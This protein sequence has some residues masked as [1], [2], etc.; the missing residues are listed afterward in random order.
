[1]Q[2]AYIWSLNFINREIAYS[3]FQLLIFGFVQRMSKMALNSDD[4]SPKYMKNS[5]HQAA[6]ATC[7]IYI[8]ELD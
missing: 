8:S 5:P 1:M 7:E 3:T 6:K 4:T 2:N